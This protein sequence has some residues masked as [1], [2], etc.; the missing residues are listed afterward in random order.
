MIT[1]S[2]DF[3]GIDDDYADGHEEFPSSGEFNGTNSV[4]DD[5]TFLS[6]KELH[7]GCNETGDQHSK[8]DGIGPCD[9]YIPTN[10]DVDIPIKIT[11]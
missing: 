8:E 3:K 9:E 7:S 10:K 4:H 5:F 2:E 11:E 6:S 1:P